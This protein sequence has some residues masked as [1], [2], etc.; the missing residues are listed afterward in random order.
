MS[1]K[2]TI[3]IGI[4]SSGLYVLEQVQNFYYENTGKNKP[5]HVEYLYIETN[6]DNR[7]G[8]TA[9]PDEIKQIYISLGNM[10][11]MIKQ[12]RDEGGA[13]MD[14][15][16]SSEHILDAGMG[17]GGIPAVGRLALWGRN[18]EGNNLNNVISAINYAYNAVSGPGA[19]SDGGV[20][21]VYVT[22]SVTGG[23]GSGTFVDLA[24][25]IRTL[26]PEIKELYSLIMLPPEP[27][28]I[29][30]NEIIYSNAHG[31]L[32]A[33]E[34]YNKVE[35]V[36]EKPGSRPLETFK[37]PPYELTQYISQSYNDGTPNLQSLGG[38]YKIA[39]LY[40]FLNVIGL[41]PK[42]TERLVDAR[43]N[44][45][46][47]KYG[48]FGLSGIQYPKAQIQEYL[49]LNLGT[50]LL[51]NWINHE[52][53]VQANQKIPIDKSKISRETSTAFT[54]FL[55]RA[56]DSLNAAGGN[57]LLR[58]IERDSIAINKNEKGKPQDALYKLYS[59]H[60]PDSYYA[61]VSNNLQS[62]MDSLITDIHGM[63]TGDINRYESL[64][65]A[66]MQLE[67]LGESIASTLQYWKTLGLSSYANKWENHLGMQ[68]NGM[69]K[70]NYK[71]LLEQDA[72][73]QDRMAVTLEQMKMHLI[74]NK[75][76]AL[77]KNLLEGE[78][79]LTTAT[80]SEVIV[81]PTSFKINRIISETEKAI[82]KRDK[83]ASAS[84]FKSLQMRK[85][86]IEGDM[87]DTSIPILRVFPSG[88]FE[89]EVSQSRQRYLQ[90][91]GRAYP[92][93]STLIQES[94]LWTYLNK[95]EKL[96]RKLYRDCILHF[97]QDLDRY[98]AVED[99]DV[100]RYVQNNPKD[101]RAYAARAISYL[102]PIRKKTLDRSVNIPKVV[103]GSNKTIIS[104]VIQHLQ[105]ANLFEFEDRG[106]HILEIQQ[107][108]NIMVFYIE[109]A[110]YDPLVDISYVDKLKQL[111]IDYPRA[112]RITDEKWFESRN[113]YLNQEKYLAAAAKNE[114]K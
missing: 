51:S 86:E 110:S 25:L 43:G 13:N 20:P 24:Y 62:A 14:W 46:I 113:P 6:K 74:I 27:Q 12:L 83:D 52:F 93:K 111:D 48:T 45:Q 71:L 95:E 7:P 70:G 15:L 54:A 101:A 8:I 92:T 88:E 30:G 97:R 53:Y 109:Q 42:R 37:S 47:G 87:S 96:H 63:I 56:F 55:R 50:E 106:D 5:A 11:T 18:N 29:R 91:A 99:Y 85:Y 44:N 68:I 16:P 61:Q 82:G 4:G 80:R 75:L 98:Q 33:L 10:A 67:A 32:R 72:V 65:Y 57:N 90:N 22:G 19:Q 114:S 66:K 21:T 107:L 40:L 104:N 79:P 58:A 39:G 41:G 26:I 59:P 77:R 23:T 1:K 64:Y 112:N 17:A 49:S 76:L 35:N 31:A 89:S 34:F 73:L 9:L 28:N 103:I 38:L 3:L 69:V 60:Q 81:L 36:Y 100:G 78:V 2:P 102:L 84:E 108:R 105:E 94:D